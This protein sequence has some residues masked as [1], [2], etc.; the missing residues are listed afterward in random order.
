MFLHQQVRASSRHPYGRD[1]E[2]S[3][4]ATLPED[5]NWAW[6]LI[7]GGEMGA[8]IHSFDWSETPLG[9]IGE[10]PQS[11]REAVSLCVRSRFQLAIY[12]GP[13]LILLYNDAERDI[14]GSM[15]P[16]VLGRPAS[17]VL[18]DIWDVVGPQLHNVLATGEA[19]W[20]VDE[21]LLLNRNGFPEE[22]FFT[23]SYS[24]ILEGDGV[25]GVLLVTCE[26]TERVLAERRL[27]ILR[28][29][30]S[31]TAKAR[32]VDEV[33]VRASTVL[34][35]HRRDLPFSLLFLTGPDGKTRLCTSTGITGSPD[36]ALWDFPAVTISQ[37]TQLVED[38]AARL[39]GCEKKLPRVAVVMPI[40]HADKETTA[41]FLVAGIS[42]FQPLNEAY[43]GYLELIAG[44]IASAIAGAR[45]LEEERHRAEALAAF[46]TAKTRFF[47]NVS[48]EFRTPLTLLLA[49]L[50][51][52]LSQTTSTLASTDRERLKIAHRNG[53]RLQQLVNELLE[54]SRIEAGRVQADREPTDLAEFTADLASMFRS[55]VERAGLQLIVDCPPLPR[56]ALVDREM[57]EKIVLNLLSNAF[58]YT[59]VGEI[60]VSQRLSGAEI[61]L[62]VRDTGVGIPEEELPRLFERFHRVKGARGR[63]LEG[64]GIGLALVQEL[65]KLHGGSVRVESAS[66]RGSTFVVCVPFKASLVVP[67]SS[68]VTPAP[69]SRRAGACLVEANRWIS[70][71]SQDG[72]VDTGFQQ[73]E[74]PV[75]Q[76]P[77]SSQQTGARAR[78][79]VADD[80]ADMRQYLVRLFESAYKV[81]QAP[82]GKAALAAARE[83]TPDLV[84]ADVMMPEMDGFAF[85]AQLRADPRT[86]TVPVLL[87][88]ARAGEESR[89]E[90]LAAGADDYLVKPFSARELLARAHSHLEMA[91][92]RREAAY[93]E[94]ELLAEVLLAQE[95][96]ATIL[97]NI[98]DGFMA[99]DSNWCFTHVNAAAESIN[100][101]RRE[102]MIGRNHWDVFPDARGSNLELE[103]RRAK[104]ENVVLQ[105]ENYYEPWNQWFHVK[106]YPSKDGG[107]SIFFHDITG[108]KRSEDILRKS[109][110]ELE[111]RVKARTHELSRANV[112]LG[113]QIAIS[114]KIEN[115][116][117]ELLGRLVRVQEEEHRRIARELHDDLTQQLA[118][119][120]IDAGTLEQQPC[121]PQKIV[122]K[123][124][125]MREQ[126]AALSEDIHSLSR[127][128]HPSI[129]DD[130]GL[131]AALRLECLGLEQRDKIKVRYDARN[132]P[133]DLP[134]DVSLCVYR[135]AQEALRNVVHH[136]KCPQASL[137]L[138]ANDSELVMCVRDKGVG[139]DVTPG[140]KT[141]LGLESMRERVRLIQARLKVRSL[142]GEGTSITMRVSLDRSPK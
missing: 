75:G 8:R 87:L 48:H 44:Q 80:N 25:G 5:R 55:P 105:F 91:R 125:G 61:V 77:R 142:R 63:T 110:D 73:T 27:S 71:Q 116:R 58:K 102:D 141:G 23:Y 64:T 26:T 10:W 78:V 93:R 59:Y 128:L 119:L 33:C 41:G 14:L 94:S 46:D 52:T 108:L 74:T 9:P 117:T 60:T 21:A 99:L 24:P 43:R 13:H 49:P 109:H 83:R 28:E 36:A 68:N 20:S 3:Q 76:K 127:Q 107:L 62:S 45:V 96:A 113:R 81:E 65:V 135:V 34:D 121:C 7:D 15:H 92:I 86:R 17:E 120:A 126:L 100:G 22:G 35:D 38:V 16:R 2:A 131:V 133:V 40:A 56:P 106:A 67:D 111:V 97:E 114:K 11:L 57:W 30:T 18:A 69:P 6:S 37:K 31:E 51:E 53:L 79:L 104:T 50:E 19:T 124:R 39:L 82:D 95:K 12:W 54:F 88:S 29:L 122:G 123:L 138:V 42:D 115:A 132:I 136:A 137:R 130:L 70:D 118:V 66:G 1:P 129:L 32:N 101:M 4:I 140:G 90:G 72:A 112:R 134:R 84:I 103:L 139:F 85:L 89:V 47:A 98:T